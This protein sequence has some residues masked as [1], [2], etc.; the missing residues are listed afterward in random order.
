M[1]LVVITKIVFL[2]QLC[3]NTPALKAQVELQNIR[4]LPNR[5]FKV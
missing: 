3:T 4:M 2:V 5:V 1:L